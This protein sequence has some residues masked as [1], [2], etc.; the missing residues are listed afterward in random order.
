MCVVARRIGVDCCAKSAGGGVREDVPSYAVH[1][2]S[3][4]THAMN[5]QA[6]TIAGISCLALTTVTRS[7]PHFIFQASPPPRY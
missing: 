7:R 1:K 4:R 6:T 3:E 2:V 5:L